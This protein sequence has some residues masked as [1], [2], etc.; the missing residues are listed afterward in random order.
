[1]AASGAREPWDGPNWE[2]F[3]RKTPQER[4][5]EMEVRMCLGPDGAGYRHSDATPAVAGAI[6]CTSL[7]YMISVACRSPSLL[8]EILPP[9]GDAQRPNFPQ[10]NFVVQT[11]NSTYTQF[12]AYYELGRAQARR[13]WDALAKAAP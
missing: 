10:S 9:N 3:C 4:E 11:L 8:G 7:A 13:A 5:A 1:V 12:G 2:P 6:P